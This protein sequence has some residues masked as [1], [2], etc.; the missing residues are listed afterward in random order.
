LRFLKKKL[1]D[2]GA[3]LQPSIRHVRTK[4]PGLHQPRWGPAIAGSLADDLAHTSHVQA[5]AEG[6]INAEGG[7]E[8]GAEGG[9]TLKEGSTVREGSTLRVVLRVGS[10]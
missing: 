3:N 1:P 7:V 2:C 9:I 4:G 10:R 5:T 8:G 6:G